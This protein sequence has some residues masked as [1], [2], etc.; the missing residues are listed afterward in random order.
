[1]TDKEALLNC[2]FDLFLIESKCSPGERY[3][4]NIPSC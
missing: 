4:W 1:M 2:R 3:G